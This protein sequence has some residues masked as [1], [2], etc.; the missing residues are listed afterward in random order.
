M[1][2]SGILRFIAVTLVATAASLV[3]AATNAP[4]P[5]YG[6]ELLTNYVPVAKALAADDLKTAQ[7]SAA[8]LS[9]QAESNGMTGIVELAKNLSKA[10]DIAKA[11]TAFKALSEEIEG[12]T[13]TEKDVTVM[14]CP[15]AAA[16]WVQPTGPVENPY[17]GK[18]MLH[19]GGPKV[20]K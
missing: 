12:L 7:R 19:C 3:S 13:V 6:C 10:A 4:A 15:M 1:A 17:F 8:A 11:R 16:I 20:A 5:K 18:A 14:Y 9:K 2:L